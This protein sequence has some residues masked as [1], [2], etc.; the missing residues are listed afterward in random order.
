MGCFDAHRF[1]EGH[2]DVG[3]VGER[4][5]ADRKR[6]GPCFPNEHPARAH[7]V[8][9][10]LTSE[11]GQGAGHETE[12]HQPFA[13]FRAHRRFERDPGLVDPDLSITEV[14]FDVALP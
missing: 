11:V 2:H 8:L 7:A 4:L 14:D 12:R 10:G 13:V 6:A 5:Q 9:D 1:R 3:A